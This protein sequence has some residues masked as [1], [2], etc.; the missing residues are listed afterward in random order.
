M[1]DSPRSALPGSKILLEGR[2]G[3]GKSYCI[4]TLID[5]GLEVFVLATE[6]GYETIYGYYADRD[7]PIPPN[8]HVHQVPLPEVSFLDL[9]DMA[10][11]VNQLDHAALCKVK[12]PARSRYNQ[13]AMILRALN[14][15][16]DDRTGKTYG[17]VDRWGTGR[18]LAIDHMTGLS[19]ASMNLGVGGRVT[20]DKPDYGIAQNN[21]RNLLRVLCNMR[22]WFVLLSHVEREVIENVG[23]VMT[24]STVGQALAPKIPAM[25]SDVILTRREGAQWYW[26]TLET[27]ADLKT[28]NLP[29][30]AKQ[31][32][33]FAPILAR[34]KSRG[35]I[36]EP[37]G[38]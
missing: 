17:R 4:G 34:W 28:R 22:A 29:Y 32:P 9:A 35:G 19:D 18:V 16:P 12:D 26:D 23:A 37:E 15:F 6:G 20:L 21:L 7:K 25:F 10:D 1:T 8:L 36:L 31:K 27:N 30:A 2:S 13:F 24:V 3:T 5:L 11:K 38:T 33:D 14:D